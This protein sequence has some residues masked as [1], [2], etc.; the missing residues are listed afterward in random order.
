MEAAGLLASRGAPFR[1]DVAGDG[2]ERDRLAAR[3]VA[4]LGLHERV[5]APRRAARGAGRGAAAR[6]SFAVVPSRYETFSVVVS[7][8]LACGLPVVATAAGRAARAHPRGQRPALPAARI[9]RRSRTRSAACS[10]ATAT[11]DRAAIAAGVRDEL[12]PDGDRRPL[13]GDLRRRRGRR[14]ELVFRSDDVA[15]A[16]AGRGRQPAARVAAPRVPARRAGRR[17]KLAKYPGIH[18]S[19]RRSSLAALRL[20]GHVPRELLRLLLLEA[21]IVLLTGCAAGLA[22]GMLGHALLGRWLTL[23]TGYPAPFAIGGIQALRLVGIVLAGALTLI[24]LAGAR[25][26]HLRPRISARHLT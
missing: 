8:A 16:P 11:Y 5:V 22:A 24:A 13:V 9:P 15:R 7:E 4:E 10:A 2:P 26:A 23:T 17:P 18:R 14:A 1:L 12:S 25:A 20:S 19:Q 3:V 21:V 6:A